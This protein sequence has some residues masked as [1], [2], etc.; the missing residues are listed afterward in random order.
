MV[1]SIFLLMFIS[2]LLFGCNRKLQPSEFHILKMKLIKDLENSTLLLVNKKNKE[3]AIKLKSVNYNDQ[4]YRDIKNPNYYLQNQKEQNILDKKNQAIVTCILDKYGYLGI[5]DVGYIANHGIILTLEHAPYN[6]KLKYLPII[7]SAFKSKKISPEVYSI[8]KDKMAIKER[9]YQEY[10]T[11]IISYENSYTFYP[12]NI[13]KT[14][15]L[16][17]NIGLKQNLKT[18]LKVFFNTEFDSLKYLTKLPILK[19]SYDI[20]DEK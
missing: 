20:I 8:Y 4:L 17:K 19:K 11:Q 2:L 5:K 14:D 16:R 9:R 10:G 15:S 6:V 7:D 12:L 18:Y 13:Q 3:L 1:K